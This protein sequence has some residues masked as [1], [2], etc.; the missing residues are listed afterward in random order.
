MKHAIALLAA[1]AL[2]LAA[3]AQAPEPDPRQVVERFLEAFNRHDV[4]AMLSLAHADVQWLTVADDK[5]SVDTAGQAALRDSM[6][7]YFAS[8]PTVRSTF[9]SALVAGPYVTVVERA[10]WQGKSGERTQ[11]ALAVYEVREG[12]VRRVWYFHPAIP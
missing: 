9:E 12:K 5:I 3:V 8:L 2:P 4:E 11:A 6:K 7:S 10:R 1:L